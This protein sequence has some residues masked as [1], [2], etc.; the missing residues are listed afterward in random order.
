MEALLK[1]VK[2][3]KIEKTLKDLLG[4]F[5]VLL[6][7]ELL[8]YYQLHSSFKGFTIWNFLFLIPVAFMLNALNGWFARKNKLNSFISII[9]LFAVSLFYLTDYMYYK[10]FGSLF[11]ASMMGVGK[12]AVSNFGWSLV[13]TIKENIGMIIIF[14]LPII[15]ELVLTF[16]NHLA[17][18]HYRLTD[19]LSNVLV[20]FAMWSLIVFALPLSGTADHTAYGAYHSRYIDTDTASNKL[21]IISNFL[22]EL[23][24][25][26]FGT[27]DTTMV[28][29]AETET[30]IEEETV[31][32]EKSEVVSYNVNE[33]I[34]FNEL[35]ELTDDPTIVALCEYL[36]NVSPSEKNEY[37]GLFEGYNLIYIC[38]ESFSS[39]AIDPEITPTLYKLANNGIVLN[40]YYN[41]FKNVTTN[42][43][44]A[45]LTG[46][47]PDVARQNT[48]MG[49]LTG[50]MGQSINKDMSLAL[51]NMFNEAEGLQ[52]RA[53]HNYLGAYY[54][55]NETLPNMGFTCKFMND[56]MT[57]T[58]SWPSSDLEMMEQSIDDY[59]NDDRFITYYMTFSGHGNYTSDNV[60]VYRN[61][62]TITS[63]VDSSYAISA[64]G[65]LSA[66]YELEKAMTYLLERL[67]EAGKL[68]NTVIV[69][70]GDH[71]PYY[72]T[73]AGYKSIT[74]E[75]I[76]NDFGSFKS[77]CIIYNAGL[78]ENI[79]VDTPCCNVDILPTV[80]N[81]FNISY[82]SRL[83]AGTDIF[84]N[85]NHIAQF[86][87]KSFVTD[88]VKYNF[89]TGETIWLIDTDEYDEDRLNAYLENMINIVKNRYAMSIEIE[90]SDFYRFVSENTKEKPSMIDIIN[91][92]ETV[93]DE[94]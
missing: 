56:G 48:N 42:G 13:A 84:G 41:S 17:M 49:N 11:S 83:Y 46:L 79:V 71:Y 33:N 66:N 38:A 29:Q 27:S 5:L 2:S 25:T 63:M 22:V 35:K 21:G 10:T 60:M 80:L 77:T 86:Y 9:V 68:E 19:R 62:N 34:D 75:D 73:D 12:S 4:H 82:D 90:E 70:T 51:G 52:S 23:R 20:A 3:E 54:G 94:E 88:Y 1:L 59:I 30:K 91:D 87:N 47:W 78:E 67:E 50:T 64:T 44:Y 61:L 40:N 15:L 31:E 8:L 72:L 36:S 37:T 32:E 28:L 85:G 39:M 76:D 7:W 74:G 65:Y 55:R 6:Y 26:F 57:F 92:E 89:A 93:S 53:Y 18:E 81:L 14:E 24:Y 43:E 45:F 69:L 16:S 58:T